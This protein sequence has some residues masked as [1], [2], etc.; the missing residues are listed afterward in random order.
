MLAWKGDSDCICA[1]C[2]GHRRALE[3]RALHIADLEWR[4]KTPEL[5]HIA[6]HMRA[7]SLSALRIPIHL[8]SCHLPYS[9][10]RHPIAAQT[11]L[12]HAGSCWICFEQFCNME[13]QYSLNLAATTKVQCD[14][15][16]VL[17]HG[18]EKLRLILIEYTCLRAYD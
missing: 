10:Q 13:S 16:G 12:R 14:R 4:W 18:Y 3:K 9:L 5:R 6:S 1:S 7:S 15:A 8:I 17:E 11:C 2:H